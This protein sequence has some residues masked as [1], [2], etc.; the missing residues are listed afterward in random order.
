M[1][2]AQSTVE[3]VRDGIIVSIAE[4]RAVARLEHDERRA[5][6]AD[7]LDDLFAGVTD[8]LQPS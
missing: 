3:A 1:S 2:S 6:V 5:N 4:L 7:W 8:G